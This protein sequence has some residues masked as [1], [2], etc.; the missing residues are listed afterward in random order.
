MGAIRKR[1]V[2]ISASLNLTNDFSGDVF[3]L[4]K[5][6]GTTANGTLTF[7]DVG[8]ADD[9]IVLGSTTY[10]LVLV[11]SAANEVDIGA[12]ATNTID[13]LVAAINLAPGE[14]TLYGI[15]TLINADASAGPGAGDTMVA[16]ARVIGTAGNAI[17]TTE[18]S[19]EASWAQTTLTGGTDGVATSNQSF[20]LTLPD[21][22]INGTTY[23]FITQD[24]GRT[25]VNNN[26]VFTDW[27]ITCL[28]ASKSFIVTGNIG[29]TYDGTRQVLNDQFGDN[30]VQTTR[31]ILISH[32]PVSVGQKVNI[33]YLAGETL[34]L[35]FFDN[36]W[37][38]NVVYGSR[39]RGVGVQ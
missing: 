10:K 12:A 34:E 1:V 21:D 18:T 9:L 19:S 3:I 22:A 14:G 30:Q 5:A 16:S 28:T 33:P 38:G 20:T 39:I 2:E 11:P 4:S 26:E 13:N 29:G 17:V 24:D 37:Y 25:I 6:G 35:T 27:N 7:T 23:T 15:G 36:I 31:E 8:N 32:S